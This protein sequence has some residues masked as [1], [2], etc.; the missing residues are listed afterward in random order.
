VSYA[1][2][3]AGWAHLIFNTLVQI[4]VGLPLEM[5]HGPLRVGCIY[6]AGVVAGS[7]GTSVFDGDVYLV[8]ASGGVY[9]L[10]AAHLANILINFN[11]MQF[12]VVRL[13]AVAFVAT[14]DMGFAL[15][16]YFT[17]G[18]MGLP[19]SYIAHLTGALAGLTLGVVLLK[20]LSQKS[21]DVLFW[22]IALGTFTACMVFAIIFNLLHPFPYVGIGQVLV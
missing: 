13:L 19:V 15:Y 22:W 1:T 11:T 16:D 17:G 3:H 7:L 6:L 2:L 5:V 20:N 10:L 8:G 14:A 21:Q 4:L 12:A 18:V 9:A